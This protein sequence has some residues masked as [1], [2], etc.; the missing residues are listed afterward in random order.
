MAARTFADYAARGVVEC[1]ESGGCQNH[2]HANARR[3]PEGKTLAQ[4]LE[5]S[6][7]E[8]PL[9]RSPRTGQSLPL[10]SHGNMLRYDWT[11]RVTVRDAARTFE[12]RPLHLSK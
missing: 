10:L 4:L 2:L 7:S 9:M 3:L 11:A 12:C 5:S 1:R 8:R 6:T